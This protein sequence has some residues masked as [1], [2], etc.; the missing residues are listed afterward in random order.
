[1][2]S[3]YTQADRRAGRRHRA[4]SMAELLIAVV[5]LGVVIV[6]V[7]GLFLMLMN[8][9]TKGLDQTVALDIAQNELDFC[10]GSTPAKWLALNGGVMGEAE[11]HPVTDS[12]TNTTFYWVLTPTE[13]SV[14]PT[15]LNVSSPPVASDPFNIALN[16]NTNAMG[17]VYRLDMDVYWWPAAQNATTIN[18][19]SIAS[20]SGFGRLSVHL[21]R[22]VYIENMKS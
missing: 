7:M 5:I 14:T 2:L 21:S 4:F 10:A 16:P 11:T 3:C 15:P 19:T 18:V 6:T 13:L 9:S 17:D 1:M 12:S 22:L 8:G 20:V